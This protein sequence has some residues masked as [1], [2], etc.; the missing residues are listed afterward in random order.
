MKKI[1]LVVLLL[2]S[3]IPVVWF[4]AFREQAIVDVAAG[5]GPNPELPAPYP[6]LIPTVNIAPAIGWPA[7]RIPPAAEEFRLNQN[8]AG[9]AHPRQLYLLPNGDVL[10]A[11]SNKPPKPDAPFSLRG[12]VMGLVMAR[13]GSGVPSANRVSL[14]RDAD[15][16]GVAELQETFL[17]GLNSRF[18]MTL[19]G[20]TLYVANTD[21]IAAFPYLEGETSITAKGEV[22]ARLPAGPINHHW[23]KDV[24]ASADG[25]K[26]YATMRSKSNAGD[27]GIEAETMRAA[28][29]EIDLAT[30][31]T[32]V[33]P[34]G[35]RN[36]N[37]LAWQPDSGALRVAVSERDGIGSD[38]VA[39][40][41][42]S[43][44]D[45]SFYGWPDSYYGQNVDVRATPPRPDL[46]Q[47]AL[48]PDYAL[49]A[50]TASLGLTFHTGS[51]FPASYRNGAFIRQRGSWNREPP[52]GYKVIFVP[53]AE[54]M[55]AGG[56]Q[57]ILT[58][59]VNEDGKAMGRPVGVVADATGALLSPMMSAIPCGGWCLMVP[60]FRARIHEGRA[61]ARLSVRKRN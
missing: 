39:D 2:A 9:F 33:F 7:G 6:G 32:R 57:D 52:S 11:Q 61:I 53:F 17:E 27:N 37:A 49:G 20:G 60:P 1:L 29:L 16:N 8:A 56:P 30:R 4:V 28:V 35:L 45:G 42:T 34:S 50:R 51:M 31:Q 54:G 46:V 24:I 38:L 14:V 23:T 19:I 36:P 41:V 59:F 48:V 22:I 15:G 12:W 3:L 10:V 40:Y 5:Y 47:S 13:A 55:P 43:V 44:R 26:L 25:T 18:G 58:G 21:A